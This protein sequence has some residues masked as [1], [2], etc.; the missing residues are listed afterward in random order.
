MSLE[1][2]DELQAGSDLAPHA[3]AT[4]AMVAQEGSVSPTAP[5]VEAEDRIALCVV[6]S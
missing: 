2:R 1:R 4:G 5:D 6:G 3:P